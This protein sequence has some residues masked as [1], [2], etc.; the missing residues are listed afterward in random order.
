ML[1][2]IDSGNT[3]TVFAVFDSGGDLKGEWRASTGGARTPDELGVWLNQLLALAEIE[4]RE[5][6]H[7]IIA[8]VVPSS[9]FTLKTLCRKYYGCDPLVVGEGDVIDL[10]IRVLMDNPEEVGADRLVNVIAGFERYG[11]PLIVVD[12]GTATTFDV[13]NDNGDYIGG[14]IAPGIN[15]SLEALHMAAAQLPR[16]AI[17]KPKHVIG[18][19]TVSAMQSGVFWGYV[20]MIEGIVRRIR[21]EYAKPMDVVATGGLAALFSDATDVI[22]CADPDLTLRG[23]YSIFKRNRT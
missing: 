4:P 5:I 8:S 16:V 15:L 12:F 22:S 6:H 18:K 13:M 21:D 3:D 19:G 14:V 9:L 2:T 10:G 17:A 20:S 11:G 23:L 1:L 7:A